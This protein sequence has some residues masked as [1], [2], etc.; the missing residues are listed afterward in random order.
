M[1]FLW[2]LYQQSQISKHTDRTASVEQRLER[3]E[4]EVERLSALVRELIGRLESKLG[5]D[6]DD[7]GRVG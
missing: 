5:A 7:D 2:D 1:G 6:L 3:T 4:D